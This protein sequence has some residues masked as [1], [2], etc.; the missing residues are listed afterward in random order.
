MTTVT[1]AIFL[2]EIVSIAALCIGLLCYHSLV[3]SRH[4]FLSSLLRAE[5]KV[6]RASFGALAWI[7]ICITLLTVLSTG[8]MLLWQSRLF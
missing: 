5:K 8:A 1:V 3:A 2:T 6:K 7:Y 4:E